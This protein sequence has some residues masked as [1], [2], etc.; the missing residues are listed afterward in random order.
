MLEEVSIH[1]VTETRDEVP[2]ARAGIR[3]RVS[4]M[5][6]RDDGPG[7]TTRAND[8]PCYLLFITVGHPNLRQVV[9]F[10]I[11]KLDLRDRPSFP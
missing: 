10:V 3:T 2:G 8:H 11:A 4:G 6:T 5:K 7:Y 9:C 1:D